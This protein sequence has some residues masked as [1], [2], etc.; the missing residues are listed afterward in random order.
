[1][2]LSHTG[3]GDVGSESYHDRLG[4]WNPYNHRCV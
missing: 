3:A 4:E 2:C 1:M